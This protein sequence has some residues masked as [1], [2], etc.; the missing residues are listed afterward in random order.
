MVSGR[1]HYPQRASLRLSLGLGA[2]VAAA[3]SRH[4]RRRETKEETEETLRDGADAVRK[5]PR[6][7]Q[8]HGGGEAPWKH[9]LFLRAGCAR[10]LPSSARGW[11]TFP[12]LD[13]SSTSFAVSSQ[14]EVV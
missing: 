5:T 2:A 1:L 13:R 6:Q 9:L 4:Q 3:A 12:G 11:C 8:E 10:V 7:A 14:G